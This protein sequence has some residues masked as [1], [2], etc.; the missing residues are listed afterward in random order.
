MIESLLCRLIY[1]LRNATLFHQA[2]Q[3]AYTDPLSK[4]NNRIALNSTLLREISRS[5]RGNQRLSLIF[6][7]VDHFKSM[8]TWLWLRLQAG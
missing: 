1:P 4:T 6:V 8:V 5:K 2:L 3:M 7:D